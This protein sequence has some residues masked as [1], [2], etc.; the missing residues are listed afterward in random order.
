MRSMVAYG[1]ASACD[2][3]LETLSLRCRYPPVGWPVL[4]L[5][6]NELNEIRANLHKDT[7]ALN[8]SKGSHGLNPHLRLSILV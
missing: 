6:A 3:G 8:F 4:S 7:L 1:D 5:T 2:L